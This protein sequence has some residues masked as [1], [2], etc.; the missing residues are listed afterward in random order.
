MEGSVQQVLVGLGSCGIAAGGRRVFDRFAELIDSGRDDSVL[1]Q[2]GCIGLCYREVLVEVRDR[3]GRRTLY[4]EV[5]PERVDRILAEHL[6]QGKVIAEWVVETSE[7]LARQQRIVL[8]NCGVIDPA[9]L[10]EYCARD[11]YRALA[12]IL[13]QMTPAQVIELISDAGL[14]GRGGAGFPT[15]TKWRLAQATKDPHKYV[16]CNA[17]EGDPGAFMDRSVLEGDPHSVLEGMAIAAYAIGASHGYVYVR[18]EYPEAVRRLRQGIAQAT[19]HGCLGAN[20]LG[21]GF[22]F[23]VALKEGAGAFVC[24]EETALIASIEGKRGMPRVRPPFP[25]ESGLW[26][27]PT[28]I[29]NVETLANVP[30]IVLHGAD[31]FKVCGTSGSKGTKVFALAGKVRRGGLVEVPMGTSINEVINEIGGG[32]VSG[33]AFKAVQMGG[34]SGGCIPARLGDTPIDYKQLTASG[35]IMGSGGMV[36]MDESTCMVDVARFFLSFT[37]NESCGKCT[38]CRIGTKRMLEI[39]E[40]ICAGQGRIEDL[41]LLAELGEQIKASSLCGLGQTAPNPVLTTLRYFLEEYQ[42]HIAD[43]RC[44]AKVCLALVEFWIDPEKC[45]GCG[46]C[47]TACDV[48]AISGEKKFPHRIDGGAC[49]KC[50]RC[51]TVCRQDAIEKR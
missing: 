13:T 45:N 30:W 17:D 32:T 16:V 18:A 15:G 7:V 46:L 43:K 9:N 48:G 24:G 26:G 39:L 34:P 23:E 11:G 38:F 21:T 33:R 1:K 25:V 40:R 22:H 50:A 41:N 14:R 37:Q 3:Q 19:G 6:H 29:N 35:A 28:C 44:P 20:I 8:R 51:L 10:D 47:V 31:A 49:V 4:G 5:S 12:K 42:V 27:H 36:V 2:T